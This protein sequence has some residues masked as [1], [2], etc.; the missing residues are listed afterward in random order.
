MQ[1][2]IVYALTIWAVGV[3]WMDW[4]QHRVPNVLLVLVLV[5]AL[6]ALLINRQG[7]LGVAIVP[8]LLALLAASVALL[9]G[10]AMG[11]MGAGD[12]KFAACLALLLGP[13]ASLRM[14]L[15][16]G[17]VLGGFSAAVFLR[18]RDDPD[19]GKRRI[20]AAP[21]LAAGFASQL[22]ADQLS[23]FF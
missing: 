20:A 17:V 12:V 18:R 22:Y 7:L 23:W 2:G 15:V 5:P 11:K 19:G 8:S 1:S 6:L 16:F 14:M 4:R 13:W 3:A 10:Y 9:P 21:A